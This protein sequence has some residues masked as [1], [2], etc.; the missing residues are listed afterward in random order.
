MVIIF[1]KKSLYEFIKRV[2][3]TSDLLIFFQQKKDII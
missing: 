2:R 3:P 1:S